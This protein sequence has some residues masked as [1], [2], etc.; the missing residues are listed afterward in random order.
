MSARVQTARVRVR[1]RTCVR[2][3]VRV[4]VRAWVPVERYNRRGVFKI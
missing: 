3:R 4:R 1:V 2:V